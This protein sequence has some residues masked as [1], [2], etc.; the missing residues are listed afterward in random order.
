MNLQSFRAA[1]CATHLRHWCL[2]AAP[3]NPGHPLSCSQYTSSPQR[4]FAQILL[5]LLV[6]WMAPSIRSSPP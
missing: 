2:R 4:V 3:D 6:V 5:L 1:K